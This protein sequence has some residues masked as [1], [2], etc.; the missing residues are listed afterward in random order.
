MPIVSVRID[1]QSKYTIEL[2]DE[3]SPLEFIETI[4]KQM[5]FVNEIASGHK[6]LN[7]PESPAA[8][9]PPRD[10]NG[11][12]QKQ[13]T[14]D[15]PECEDASAGPNKVRTRSL[16]ALFILIALACGGGAVYLWQSGFEIFPTEKAALPVS[17]AAVPVNSA[18]AEIADRQQ[19]AVAAVP[20]EPVAA[21][22]TVPPLP[23][24]NKIVI[25][26]RE[27]TWMRI[28]EDNNPAYDIM[29]MPGDTLE[30]EAM[31]FALKIG[32]AGGVDITFNNKQIA[33]KPGNLSRRHRNV[34][35]LNLPQQ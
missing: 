20:G 2:E 6:R 13:K 33:I 5:R 10:G 19:S 32:N 14:A 4:Q 1:S 7:P 21:S 11:C 29:L 17:G 24:L 3:Y 15:V 28:A 22:K 23:D 8:Q 31:H 25:N 12:P 16:L 18:P 27:L 34:A 26:V 9:D 30:R 35:F